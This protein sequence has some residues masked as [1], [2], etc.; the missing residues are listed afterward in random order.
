MTTEQ[1]N[2]I[3]KAYKEHTERTG[4]ADRELATNAIGYLA[5]LRDT[6]NTLGYDIVYPRDEM[7]EICGEPDIWPFW[8]IDENIPV[9]R[10]LAIANE[11]DKDFID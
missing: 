8:L 11:L 9:L 10:D 4:S 7:A 1:R 5:G 6:L 2:E 3:I